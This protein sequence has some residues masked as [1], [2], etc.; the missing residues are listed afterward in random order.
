MPRI[1]VTGATGNV[2][3]AVI[4]SLLT[5]G[6]HVE[7]VAGARKTELIPALFTRN[8]V[9]TV[10]FDFLAP[11]TFSPAMANADILFLLRPPPISDAEKVFG[12]LLECAVENKLRHI[13][14]LSVQG[15][16]RSRMIPHN[17]IERLILKSGISYTFLRPAY[18]MQNFLTSLSNDL[19]LNSRI[20]L[21]AGQ[22]R[23]T[24][25]DVRDIG[26]V[27]A[28]IVEKID[29]YKNR[30]L[31]LTSNDLLTFGDM[32]E[33]LTF[34]L[35]RKISYISPSIFTFYR[36]KRAE[37]MPRM[38]ILVMIMLHFW[39]RFKKEPE[40]TDTIEKILKREPIAFNQ[41]ISDYKDKL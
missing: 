37:K 41:F 30:A 10:E 22:A 23:F 14:F 20:F 24:L 26:A 8:N 35:G 36:A 17:K 15:A 9:R 29:L 32:A 19:K 16:E 21:P 2:G 27:T 40:T 33:S 31:E 1:F 38:L 18:F 12:P 7:I 28:E 3:T 4:H 34:G 39:P 5:H 6:T 13:I 11:S 25:V